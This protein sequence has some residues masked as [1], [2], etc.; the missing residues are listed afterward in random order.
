[1]N[2]ERQLCAA[3]LGKLHEQIDRTIHLVSLTPID[4][5]EWAPP[6]P[7]AWPVNALL[8]HLLDCMAGFCAVLAAA[9][10]ERLAQFARLREWP[11]NQSCEP[12][13][14]AAWIAKYREH[15]DQG[16]ALLLDQD[17]GRRVPTVFVPQGESVLT[18]L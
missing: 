14:A 3:V 2:E 11:V 5:L 10:P 6:I 1:M 16:F 13:V 9:E 17:L 15:I 7:G 8:G 18:L 4:R 12:A